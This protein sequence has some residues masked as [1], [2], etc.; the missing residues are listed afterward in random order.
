L[1]PLLDDRDVPKAFCLPDVEFRLA[2]NKQA[3][4]MEA[5]DLPDKLI[6][7]VLITFMHQKNGNNGKQWVFVRNTHNSTLCFVTLLLRIFKRFIFLLGW[8]ATATPLAIYQTLAGNI[9]AI[10]ADDIN[11]A[12][13]ATAA[14]VYSLH[15]TK[16]A[17]EIQ[18]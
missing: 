11:V 9:R 7:R 15:P 10:T 5:F 16:H 18:L 17:R 6:H 13:R 2:N 3:T 12:M 1:S 4:Q 8:E 14:A